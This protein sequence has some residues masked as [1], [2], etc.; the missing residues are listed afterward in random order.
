M[1]SPAKEVIVVKE[2]SPVF[3]TPPRPGPT[4][5]TTPAT[6][7]GE[8]PLDLEAEDEVFLAPDLAANASTSFVGSAAKGASA[9]LLPAFVREAVTNPT[10][11]L[12]DASWLTPPAQR[13]EEDK[14]V[15]SPAPFRGHAASPINRAVSPA[16][17]TFDLSTAN[18]VFTPVQALFT[19][20]QPANPAFTPFQPSA[21]AALSS[22]SPSSPGPL[23]SSSPVRDVLNVSRGNPVFS[24]SAAAQNLESSFLAAAPFDVA[25]T[26]SATTTNGVLTTPVS[27]PKSA[28][29]SV[30]TPK[31]GDLLAFAENLEIDEEG[32]SSPVTDLQANLSF[33]DVADQE[34]AD[35]PTFGGYGLLSPIRE[36]TDEYA[37]QKKD[38]VAMA[39]QASAPP[40][41]AVLAEVIAHPAAIETMVAPTKSTPEK[42]KVE[43]VVAS[44][45]PVEAAAAAPMTPAKTPAAEKVQAVVEEKAEEKL[46]TPV[47]LP[48]TP[49]KTPATN[50]AAPKSNNDANNESL[51]LVTPAPGPSQF[52]VSP[53]KTP[54]QPH[55]SDPVP[56]AAGAA[57]PAKEPSELERIKQKIR[58]WDVTSPSKS[59][60]AET[61]EK[62]NRFTEEDLIKA[63]VQAEQAAKETTEALRCQFVELQKKYEAEK[64]INAEMK[65]VVDEF[66]MSIRV[67]VDGH[68][69]A[70][71]AEKEAQAKLQSDNLAL[72]EIVEQ[73]QKRMNAL[74]EEK[75]RLN[76]D[77]QEALA[78]AIEAEELAAKQA[79]QLEA[80]TSK[81]QSLKQQA[82]QKLALANERIQQHSVANAEQI[83]QMKTKLATVI[84]RNE[85]LTAELAAKKKENQELVVICNQ[86]VMQL[87]QTAPP[88]K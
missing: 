83:A 68:K 44:P 53:I 61:P 74:A 31:Q 36:D 29:K 51:K 10:P 30:P 63:R 64:R 32:Q 54:Q 57:T 16:P 60:R 15:S 81:Y 75:V 11:V 18:P 5:P 39:V 25:E 55:F 88:A 8:L 22:S 23:P 19:P 76:T 24:P 87:E 71:Q 56:V 3:S 84:T 2:P 80:S 34:P 7:R 43:T 28:S 58:V 65:E 52:V 69:A 33:D 59:V 21:A 48:V 62:K 41:H 20:G 46:A 79:A 77:L 49:L 17:S 47:F 82:E 6:V 38:E 13:K 86:I 40:A 14:K 9:S 35:I 78:A 67:M 50:A 85:E 66:E 42:P 45:A 4:G 27:T 70:M 37:E 12:P 73:E 1:A 26:T 72:M